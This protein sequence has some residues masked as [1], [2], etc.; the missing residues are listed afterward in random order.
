MPAAIDW[1]PPWYGSIRTAAEE[2]IG[3]DNRLAVLNQQSAVLSLTNHRG[4]PLSFVEPTAMPDGMA[5]E[6]FISST[7]QV[8]TRNNLHDFFN[9]LV[10]LSFPNIKRQLN[11]LQAAQIERTGIGK[12]R[13]PA[14]D[15]AT[16]FDENCAL[17]V[18]SSNAQG[19]AL[20]GALS[21]HQWYSAFL[22]QRSAFGRYAE[23]WLFGHALMEKLVTPYKSITAHTWVVTAPDEFFV[24]EHATRREWLDARVASEL[25][26]RNLDGLSTACFTPLPVL[27]IPGWWHAQDR[28]FYDDTAV[29]RPKSCNK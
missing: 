21:N 12:A 5:Y 19:V 18:V 4:L 13:G 10:W 1:T 27:G 28:D 29:F 16:L 6:A 11:A 25:M 2:V 23:V 22:D 26:A 17:L 24:M 20:V 8:P 9:A 7:G 14:R 3:R 15:A